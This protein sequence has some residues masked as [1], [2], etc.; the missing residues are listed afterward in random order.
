VA[1]G[2]TLAEAYS[3]AFDC[4]RTSAFGGIVALNRTLDAETAEADRRNLHRGRHRARRDADAKAVFAAKKNLR[5]L[6]TGGLPDPR[7]SR[8]LP[9]GRSPAAYLVQDDVGRIEAEKLRAVTRR[10][11]SPHEMADMIF[12]WTVA[13]HVKSN[14]IVYA[15]GRRH[16]RHRR[17]PDEPRRL[18]PHRRPEG[19]GHGRSAG[20]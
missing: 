20:T 8:R 14:A 5:L 13:K 16:G 9:I 19:A 2:A 7:R 3:R 1:R 12:A 4:D 15:K 17:G 6:T 11:P 10:H 18:Q